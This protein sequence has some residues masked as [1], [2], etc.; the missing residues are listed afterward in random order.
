MLAARLFG[1]TPVAATAAL[2]RTSCLRLLAGGTSGA[3]VLSLSWRHLRVHAA[4]A[5]KFDASKLQSIAR[6]ADKAKNSS[7]SSDKFD[8]NLFWY[9]L[10]P[11]IWIIACATAVGLTYMLSSE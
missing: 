10:R 9:Y 2:K 5:P 4:E 7:S 1:R 8:W 11:Q 6:E 3:A